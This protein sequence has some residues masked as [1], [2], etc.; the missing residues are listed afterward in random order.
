MASQ[1]VRLPSHVVDLAAAD[2]RSVSGERVNLRPRAFE[3]LRL[4]AERPGDLLT[5]DEI[6]TRV[7]D[8]VA[9]TEDS[10]TQCIAEIRRAIGDDDRRVVRTVSRK[11]YLLVPVQHGAQ[12]S[13]RISDRPSLAVMPFLAIG[14]RRDNMLGVGVASQIINELARNKN[15]RLIAR[16]SSFALAG[17]YAT[18]REIGEQLGVCYLVEGTVQRLKDTLLIDVQ[19]VDAP[20]GVIGWGDR[21]S[22]V[23]ARVPHVQQEIASRIAGSLHSTMREMQKHAILSAGPRDLDVYELTLRGIAHKHQ[24]NPEA[25]RAGRA[26]C[27]EAIRRDPNYAPAWAYLAWL[28]LIDT[29]LHF[30]GEWTFS[31]LGEVIGQFKRAIELDPNLPAP[32]AGLSQALVYADDVPQ[33]LA[34][35]R[36]AVELAPNDADGLIFLANALFE[37]GKLDEAKDAVEQALALNPL[38]PPFYHLFGAMVFWG[39]ELYQ[40]ALELAEECLRKAPNF[41]GADTYRVMALVGLGRLD[42]AKAQLAQIMASPGGLVTVV[43]HPPELAARA[44]AG[45]QAAGLRPSIV[46]ERKAV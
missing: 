9:V 26:D 2:L 37:A 16:D 1:Q 31:R 32:F 24:F 30:T 21:F 45:L 43:P 44:L 27:E 34:M 33:A 3:V 38:P 12:W 18:A 36:R 25:T 22:A 11:G 28:N 13:S 39:C 15:L 20:E 14:G 5:K 23:A 19:L 29:V 10:L 40:R 4:L 7:W 8:D 41:R 17:R 35:A 6:M 46:S 42:E